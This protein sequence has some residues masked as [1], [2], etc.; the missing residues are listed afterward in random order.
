MLPSLSRRRS[1]TEYVCVES[2]FS[3]ASSL[4]HHLALHH[5]TP[6]I[7][8][9]RPGAFTNMG[10]SGGGWWAPVLASCTTTVERQRLGVHGPAAIHTVATVMWTG[11]TVRRIYWTVK[12]WSLFILNVILCDFKGMLRDLHKITVCPTVFPLWMYRDQIENSCK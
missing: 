5:L 2:S 1:W 6:S 3:L 11:L 9:S 12:L 10:W 8:I 4:P 7:S